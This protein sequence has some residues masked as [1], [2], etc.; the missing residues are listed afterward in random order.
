[1][2]KLL[3]VFAILGV[4][5]T[6]CSDD[7][8]DPI[9]TIGEELEGDITGEVTLDATITYKLTG[10]LSVKDG[11][12][13]NIPAGTTIKATGGFGSYLIV[14]QGGKINAIGSASSPIVFTS[15]ESNPD[16]GDWGGLIIN[17]YAPI[18]GGGTATCEM[19]SNIPYG[20]DNAADNSGTLQYVTLEYTGAQSD[21]N[22]EHNGLTLDAVGS[23]TKIE[24]IYVYKSADDGIE[25]FGGSVNVTNLLSVS[26]D[27]DMF[28]VTQGWNG[29]LRN[30][31]GIWES[32]FVSTEGDPR[33]IEAD[34]NFDGI[35]PTHTGQSDF[36]I[37]NVTIKNESNFVMTDGIK[38]RRGATATIT[39]A[40]IMGGT[41]KDIIDLTDD[42]GNANTATSIS[43][44]VNKSSFIG[45]EIKASGTYE[46]VSIVSD[47]AGASSSVFGWT[48]YD[49]EA[50]VSVSLS[51]DVTEDTRLNAL[52]NYT[53]DGTL[54]VKDGATLYIPA[55][56]TIKATG[57]F[58]SYVIVEQGGKI[59]AEGTASAPIVFT[60]GE[61]NPDAGDWGGLILN[62]YA[63]ISGGGT[64]TCEM[65]SNIPYGG[66][67]A[68]DDSG[69][70][71]YVVLE[72]TGAQSD[73]NIEHNGLT[74]DAVGSGTTI[75]NIYV[76]KS[77]DDGIEFFGGSVNVTNLLSVSCDD[78]MFDVTQGWNGTL[79]N[80]YG[81]WE[82]GFVSTEGD[83]RGIEAD[84]NF[85]G[86]YPTHT[87]QSDFTI[88]DVTIKNA[89]SFEM[90]D[91]IK[92]RRGATA[93]ITNALIMG[94]TAKDII[95]LTD[96]KGDANVAT[97]LSLTVDGMTFS[98]NEVKSNGTY[99][100]VAIVSGNTGADNT[101]FGWTSY[102]F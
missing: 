9:P 36:T 82:S 70:L 34:G 89:S 12:V 39:N 29:T 60:S 44:T 64:A 15:G 14:E 17:G 49:F 13:L 54:S 3:Y 62:G 79:S 74:L 8:D 28:D 92:I 61:S 16:A 72:Y 97:T 23:G 84:G 31:Y 100:N 75:E 7:N 24:N 101:A 46:G 91:G 1:M 50:G 53:L 2:K 67:E 65:D 87:G 48:G 76:Y 42:K 20:G 37:E 96:D 69:V 55:G 99:P 94:G 30:A 98:G 57:G 81:I 88:K 85:D 5:F 78:D 68:N 22:I 4:L 18:S 26:C 80:A 86:I 45:N 33:G 51:G 35:Y 59:I 6:G 47:N 40:L 38:I 95:D 21:D 32:D 41:A 56:T 58:G 63:P 52:Y 73:D 27:D 11:G 90:T 83:P 43:L 77:A 71:K 25:F 102:S 93:T 66:T 10:T 19:D